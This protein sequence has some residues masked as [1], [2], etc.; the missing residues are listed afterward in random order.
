[1]M[2]NHRCFTQ[3]KRNRPCGVFIGVHRWLKLLLLSAVAIVVDAGTLRRFRRRTAEENG[4]SRGAD[5]LTRH[6][7]K[8]IL[9][10]L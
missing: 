1:M 5:F 6:G 9:A 8:F 4:A 10:M 3:T 7:G 2:I